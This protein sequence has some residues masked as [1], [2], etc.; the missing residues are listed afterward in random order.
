MIAM[1]LHESNVIKSSLLV[2]TTSQV[3]VDVLKDDIKDLVQARY[4]RV[5]MVHIANNVC[6]LGTIYK[7]GM[8]LCHGFPADLPDFCEVIQS[9]LVCN[10]LVFV[11]GAT[12][13]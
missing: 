12:V 9:I 10:E 7:P 13:A 3:S 1:H 6:L 2:T 8:L 11:V 5:T 4:P